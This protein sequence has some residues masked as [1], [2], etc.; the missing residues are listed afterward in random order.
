MASK[1]PLH[2]AKVPSPLHVLVLGMDRTTS[3]SSDNPEL[4]IRAT[5][6]CQS[7]LNIGIPYERL[8]LLSTHAMSTLAGVVLFP[9]FAIQY[10]VYS[11]SPLL[12][13]LCPYLI[14]KT[15]PLQYCIYMFVASEPLCP[16]Y[17]QC[18]MFIILVFNSI[19]L[20]CIHIRALFSLKLSASYCSRIAIFD[21]PRAC[22]SSSSRC[23]IFGHCISEV[24]GVMCFS[25]Y[26]SSHLF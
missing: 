25:L 19:S 5:S 24:D 14:T 16:I 20:Y 1:V 21:A 15:N 9:L 3:R 26:T 11:S 10:D 13:C 2:V 6:R 7:A 17:P 18:E 12:L 4:L 23:S 22:A 8:R